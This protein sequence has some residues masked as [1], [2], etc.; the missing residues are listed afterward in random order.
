MGDGKRWNIDSRTSS[1]KPLAIAFALD[2][3]DYSDPSTALQSEGIEHMPFL[4]P[5]VIGDILLATG[6]ILWVAFCLIVQRKKMVIRGDLNLL[7]MLP[8]LVLV[9]Y[10][11][12]HV[13]ST[14]SPESVAVLLIAFYILTFFG[15]NSGGVTEKG[16]VGTGGI[17]YEWDRIKDIWFQTTRDKRFAVM[18]TLKGMPGVRHFR[19]A[20]NDRKNMSKLIKR[21]CG[22]TPANKKPS[23]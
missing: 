5:I 15:L 4:T 23:D 6:L 22:K 11:I 17:V 1:G 19:M 3:N 9:G 20:D 7:A 8:P 12:W 18:Y 10:G 2:H 14:P 13:F 16:I 21:C